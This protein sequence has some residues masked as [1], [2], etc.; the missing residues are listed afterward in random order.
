MQFWVLFDLRLK[1]HGWWHPYAVSRIWFFIC[2]SFYHW[3]WD[4]LGKHYIFTPP[5]K[6]FWGTKSLWGSEDRRERSRVD[7][8][9]MWMTACWFSQGAHW[10]LLDSFKVPRVVCWRGQE[11]SNLGSDPSYSA[12][13]TT[14]DHNA[15]HMT[16]SKL[17]QIPKNRE[18]IVSLRCDAESIKTRWESLM[19][20]WHKSAC[21]WDLPGQ[22]KGIFGSAVPGMLVHPSGGPKDDAGPRAVFFLD[23]L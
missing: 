19:L 7:G 3:N 6:F 12:H 16:T 21:W 22:I 17:K 13:V 2:Q 5:K 15:I 20:T 14:T 8:G 9:E 10:A 18:T 11:G 23:R 1:S 4:S